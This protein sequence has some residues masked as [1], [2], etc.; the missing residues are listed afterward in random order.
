MQSIYRFRE[1]E[2]GLFLKARAKV[3]AAC[4]SNRCG[5]DANFRSDHSIV[6]WV[7]APFHLFSPVAEDITTG[8]I[9]FAASVPVKLPAEA[10]GVTLYPFV[11]RDDAAEAAG[12]ELA[13]DVRA[14][15]RKV[16]ILVR[17]RSHL[18][19]FSGPARR[20]PALPRGGDRLPGGTADDPRPHVP[21]PR[22]GAPRRPDRLAGPAARS[23]VRPVPADLN[24][25]AGRRR[26][27]P[28]WDPFTMTPPARASSGDARWRLPRFRAALEGAVAQ[29]ASS[30]VRGWKA[31]GWRSAGRPAPPAP[32]TAKTPAAFFDL[33]EEMDE[34]LVPDPAAMAE[35]I[36]RPIC[37]PRPAGR[38]WA[39]GH[40]HPQGQGPGV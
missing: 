39:S 3:S 21:H 2:V 24:A 6:D 15:G 14:R 19:A 17:A 27:R 22:A 26:A 20:G 30:C 11:G 37:R 7:N 28:L 29:R 18:A 10:A 35:R 31:R 5:F 16:A 12:V 13:R 40:D 33:M 1:A 34:R 4:R 38:R 9:P 8:A 32:P 36:D 25:L 23:V